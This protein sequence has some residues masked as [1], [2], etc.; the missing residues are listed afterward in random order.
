MEFSAG[1]ILLFVGVALFLAV[2]IGGY[3]VITRKKGFM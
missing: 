2:I 3:M 1:E